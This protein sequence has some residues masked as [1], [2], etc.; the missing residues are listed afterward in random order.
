MVRAGKKEFTGRKGTFPEFN[1]WK[2]AL[3]KGL[4]M[5]LRPFDEATYLSGD[6][7]STSVSALPMLW[8][9]KAF[10]NNS[11]LFDLHMQQI[12]RQ[13][14]TGLWAGKLLEQCGYSTQ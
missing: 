11:L 2:W 14:Q 6:Q 3:M 7:Y 10:L 12:Q 4:R 5:I 13:L 9:V 1:Q 8:K